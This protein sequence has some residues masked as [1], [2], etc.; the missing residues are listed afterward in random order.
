MK[1]LIKYLHNK[2]V[3]SD[4]PSAWNVL[5]D[6][7]WFAQINFQ[8]PA[9]WFFPRKAFH[10]LF[11]TCPIQ[12]VSCLSH[13]YFNNILLNNKILIYNIYNIIFYFNNNIS[14]A[15][16]IWGYCNYLFMLPLQP[17]HLFIVNTY[18][19]SGTEKILNMHWFI[20]SLI[21]C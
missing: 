19:V 9:K 16:P 12:A 1:L 4:Y 20:S 5:T 11:P 18:T 8:D 14:Y 7:W 6:T 3:H 21:Y 10:S 15:I 13:C 17:I 2:N